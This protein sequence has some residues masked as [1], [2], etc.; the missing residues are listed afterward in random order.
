MKREEILKTAQDIVCL[1]RE[2]PYGKP[3]D[4]FKII[5]DLWSTY[6]GTEITSNDVAMMMIMLKIARC[7]TGR[8]KDDNYIDIAG[9]AACA[10]EIGK[11]GSE[12]W[13]D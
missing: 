7:K 12:Q 2:N 11:G 4:N 13:N 1:D 6:I 10:G 3:E 5:A 9:Y 8:H